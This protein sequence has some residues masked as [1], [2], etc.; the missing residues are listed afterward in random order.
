ML[1]LSKM[2]FPI[3]F[4]E[5]FACVFKTWFI[6]KKYGELSMIK[7]LRKLSLIT[8]WAINCGGSNGYDIIS[9]DA[10]SNII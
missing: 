7:K 2:V 10:M 6:N 3:F 8:A 1:Q 5:H 9:M 4:T